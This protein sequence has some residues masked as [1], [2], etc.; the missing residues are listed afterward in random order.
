MLLN[1]GKTLLQKLHIP[2]GIPCAPDPEWVGLKEQLAVEP[3]T[4]QQSYR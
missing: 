4:V 3:K 2:P 1:Q